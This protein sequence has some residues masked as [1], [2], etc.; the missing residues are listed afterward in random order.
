L[1]ALEGLASYSTDTA[2]E[3]LAINFL[4][5]PK[6]AAQVIRLHVTAK[7]SGRLTL[8]KTQ[9]DSLPKIYEL[10][11]MDR[12]KKDSLDIRNNSTYVFDIDRNDTLSFGD[13]RFELVIRQNKAL[14]IHL[15]DFRAAKATGG[16]QLTW[17]AENEENYTN[18]TVERSTDNGVSFSVLGGSA[19]NSQDTYTF[20]DGNPA[21]AVNIYR[22][23]IEDLNGTISYTKAIAISY[24]PGTGLTASTNIAVYPNPAVGLINLNINQPGSAALNLSGVQGAGY[25]PAPAA[26]QGSYSIKIINVSGAVIQSA[27]SAQQTWQGD[28]SALQPGTYVLQVLNNK[29]KSVVGKVTFVKL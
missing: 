27:T 25:S 4:P 16:V 12:Y 8:E 14:G 3:A 19:S 17:K 2:P 5:L 9:L 22:V 26:T 24:N 11:L 29:D 13:K 10:W 21:N 23:K 20:L 1:G 7:N 28:V 6:K 15:L 18:F